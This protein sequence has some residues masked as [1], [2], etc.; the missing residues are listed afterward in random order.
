MTDSLDRELESEYRLTI[1]ARD[2]NGAVLS[3][4]RKT[5]GYV[6]I[7][8]RD[9]N[10]FTPRFEKELYTVTSLQENVNI[11]GQVILVRASDKDEGL[12]GA[13]LYSIDPAAGNA[14]GIFDIDT[15]TGQVYVNRSLQGYV[16]WRHFVVIGQDQGVPRLNNRTNIY[17]YV[18]DVNDHKPKIEQPQA[19]RTIYITEVSPKLLP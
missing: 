2:N 3:Q 6:T 11:G 18:E 7:K 17:V 1:E 15:A 16:G 9:I 19:N 14:S 13:I 10:D 4:Q 12:N 8:V 5:P